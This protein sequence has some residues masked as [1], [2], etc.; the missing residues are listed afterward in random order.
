M[1]VV[2][3][4]AKTQFDG[5]SAAT[6]EPTEAADDTSPTP[7][8]VGRYFIFRQIAEG[9]MGRVLLGYDE[10][11]NRKLAI[12]LWRP[13]A[14]RGE[15]LRARMLRE[16]QAL[17]R[18]SHPNVVHVYEV[19]DHRDLLYL[20]M[21][22]VEGRTLREWVKQDRP[23]LPR[24]VERYVQAGQ[25]L[26]AAHRAGVLHR[27][28]K[29]DNAVVGDDG[30]VRV[31]DFGL[32]RADSSLSESAVTRS[33]DDLQLLTRDGFDQPITRAG[34]M[35]GTPVYMSP[36][37]LTGGDTDA[38]SDI[39]SFCVALWEAVYGQRPFAG[40][41][42]AELAAAI[43]AQ[44]PREPRRAVPGWLRSAL[45]RGLARAPE[46][47]WAT[48]EDLLATLVAGARRR[49]MRVGLAVGL[50][51]A[52]LLAAGV[53]WVA[54]G[55]AREVATCV[56]R[57]AEIDELWNPQTRAEL[58]TGLLGSRQAFAVQTAD[59]VD[60]LLS[61]YVDTWSKGQVDACRR[62]RV[63]H[64]WEPAVGERAELCLGDR[65]LELAGLV[66]VLR[67][68]DGAMVR[69]A[70]EAAASLPAIDLCLDVDALA[71]R[72]QP[73]REPEAQA[74]AAQLRR[75][76]ARAN[77]LAATG[78][79]A[80]SF[81]QA[82]AVIARA[83]ALGW[84]SL[85]AEARLVAGS[86]AA[87]LGD[88]DTAKVT[89]YFED[90][91]FLA[92]DAGH[93]ATATEAALALAG[94]AGL[95][96]LRPA[97]GERWARL[98]RSLLLRL[99]AEGRSLAADLECS[100]AELDKIQRRFAAAGAAFD[101][102]YNARIVAHGLDH[103]SVALALAD[104]ASLAS[105][106]EDPAAARDL[107][108]RALASLEPALGSDHPTIARVLGN[109]GDEL[110]SLGENVEAEASLRR[111]LTIDTQVFGEAHERVGSDH[112]SLGQLYLRMGRNEDAKLHLGRAA[113]LFE[114]V[115]GMGRPMRIAALSDLVL[116]YQGLGELDEALATVRTCIELYE[117]A[118]GSA[119]ASLM[120]LI[121]SLAEIHVARGE[122]DDAAR[123]LARAQQMIDSKP[124]AEVDPE[125]TR[126]LAELRAQ[127][128][129]R[130]P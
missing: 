105:I 36:E 52:A 64:S 99:G 79:Y 71:R 78:R 98:A 34:S 47:R 80:D 49:R 108:R 19:G 58:R 120:P 17:A 1:R 54:G 12:K 37:Q 113:T 28:F 130:R 62:V 39:Y 26:A 97:E 8:R 32:A 29:P 75:E 103:P 59:R 72:P 123:A 51:L 57:G 40:A 46:L 42:A 53:A 91:L 96:L 127:L 86:A 41:N 56:A 85:R 6:L 55:R 114:G 45:L 74:E 95:T 88:R 101:R 92:L 5:G 124:V 125:D 18:L 2:E 128:A 107:L 94:F 104:R 117:G 87:S 89:R 84:P 129:A 82:E 21:E 106:Q 93:D 66:E 16:A 115:P 76:L 44:R 67:E 118:V 23:E 65:R 27:D 73:P 38:R 126:H 14:S 83:D 110:A 50:G 20:A 112:Y 121:F 100:V 60:A 10:T 109:L 48:M 61:A 9:G 31:L 81:P 30:R 119:H 69:Q 15:D 4:E 7:L 3:S 68:A 11:L 63:E 22:Y 122:T 43:D 24:L 116:A 77:S 111:A 102:C 90:A 13:Q 35:L 25:G 70:V 33:Q